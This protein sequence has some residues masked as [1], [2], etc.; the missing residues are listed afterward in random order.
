MDALQYLLMFHY[1]HAVRIFG[2]KKVI[3]ND[4]ATIVLWNSGDKTVVKC[5]EGEAY[6]PEK[7]LAMAIAKFALGNQGNYYEVFKKWLPNDEEMLH[8][9]A[10]NIIKCNRKIDG[11]Y[12]FI[13]DDYSFKDTRRFE[14]WFKTMMNPP[15]EKTDEHD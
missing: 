9:K 12:S 13:P 3:F 7:G 15:E 1:C 8:I 10:K 4:P 11:A 6:D 2:I 14:D 5:G